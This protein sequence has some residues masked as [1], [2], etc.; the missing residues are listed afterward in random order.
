MPQSQRG[1]QRDKGVDAQNFR[2]GTVN[3][4]TLNGKEGQVVE[5]LTRRRIDLCCVQEIKWRGGHARRVMGKDSYYKFFWQGDSLGIAGVGIVLADKWVD[6]VVRVDRVSD[7]IITLELLI[8]KTVTTFISVYAPHSGRS[9]EEKDSF[10]DALRATVAKIADKKLVIIA[11]DLNGHVGRGS[12]GYEGIHGGRGYGTRNREGDRILEFGNATDMVV[13]NT[14]FEKKDNRL[15]TYQSGEV[16]TQ[17]DYILISRENRKLVRDVKVISGEEIAPQHRLVIGDLCLESPRAT[18]KTFVPRRKTWKLK[19]GHTAS[20]FQT[21]FSKNVEGVKEGHT[22]EGKWAR[23][24]DNLLHAADETCG[25]TKGPSKRRETWWWNKDVD[26]AVKEK[27]RLFLEWKFRGAPKEPYNEAKR[28]ADKVIDAAQ[29]KAHNSKFPNIHIRDDEKQELFKVAKQ[30]R[31]ANQDVVGEQCIKDDTGTLACTVEAQKEAWRSHYDRL[32]NIEF[33]WDRDNLPQLDPIEGPIKIDRSKVAKAIKKMKNGK[34][35]GPSGV[36]AEMLKAAGEVGIDMVHDLIND[37]VKTGEIPTDW[38]DSIIINCYKGKGD[39]TD[40]GN[41]RGLKL[42]DHVM[43]VL[44]RVVD[45]LIRSIVNVDN[46]QFGFMPG[47][48]TTDAIFI[49]RQLQERHLAKDKTLYLAFVDLEKAFDRV[50]RA[51]LWW[52]M[53]KLGVPEVLI[54]TV[55]AMYHN[56]SASVRV[57]TAFS[58]PFEVKVGVH[59]GSVLS[60]LLFIMVL[61]AL[62][63]EFRT[64]CPWELLYADDLV[65]IARTMEELT[66]KLKEWKDGMESKGLRVNMGKTKV[67]VSNRSSAVRKQ[68]KHPCA[69][70]HKGVRKNSIRCSSCGL[71]VHKRCSGIKTRLKEDPNFKCRTCTVVPVQQERPAPLVLD[72]VTLETVDIFCYLGDTISAGGGAG[73]SVVTRIRCG[74]GKFRELLPVLTSKRF[75]LCRKGRLFGAC[76]RTV[77]LHGCE[78]WAVKEEDMMRLERADRAMIRWICGISFKDRIPSSELRNRLGLRSIDDLMRDKRLR[79]Y[80]HVERSDGAWIDKCRK[81]PKVEGGGKVGRPPK[82]WNEVLKNDFR[83][84]GVSPSWAEDRDRWRAACRGDPNVNRDPRLRGGRRRPFNPE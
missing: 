13:L 70:C 66:V 40:R 79:W 35:A 38:Q 16:S 31:K 26:K 14:M 56:A 72:D 17:I 3:L 76:V 27:R 18:K 37:V 43:K 60:P 62:S 22:V 65:I 75:S 24:K 78:T 2:I 68:G 51:V 73:E 20:V 81:L 49:V 47:R 7:R 61:E 48:G 29:E 19:N 9:E 50:P 10:Y 15:I 12:E 59:Q 55:Q 58:D 83:V 64:G 4:N 46:M 53:R 1:R 41:Y 11:G 44:E 80:G 33:D 21:Q 42:L 52:A 45:G 54:R 39:A 28:N 8:G 63:M 36:C 84:R 77:I 57:G 69:V 34:A 30:M 71:W 6:K 74:W 67:M 32:L 5:T 82:S 25:W 23:L